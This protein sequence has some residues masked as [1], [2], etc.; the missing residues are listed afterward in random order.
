MARPSLGMKAYVL[1]N[2]L[3]GTLLVFE[4][5]LNTCNLHLHSNPQ[6]L[7]SLP[8]EPEM[9]PKQNKLH[10]VKFNS[11]CVTQTQPI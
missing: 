11:R 2:W 10:S 7:Y 3:L 5:P 8:K 9:V 1:K 4:D 6:A